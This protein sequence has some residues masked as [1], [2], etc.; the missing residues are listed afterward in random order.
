MPMLDVA[1]RSA[2][3]LRRLQSRYLPTRLDRIKAVHGWTRE[4]QLRYLI[5]QVRA[6]P[7]RAL[8]VELGVWQGRSVLALAEACRGTGK[9][10]FAIDPWADYDEGGGPVSGYLA[11]YGVRSFEEVYQ[12]YLAHCRRLALEEWIVTVRAPSVETARTWSRGPVSLVFID[13][14]HHY[15]AVSADLEAWVPLVRPDGVVCGDDWEWDSVRRAVQDFVA[16][17][18]GYAIELPCDNTWAFVVKPR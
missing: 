11:Q 7:D 5:R 4:V 1:R 15:D 3:L 10:V 6:L 12:A 14:S 16:R 8:V 17:H 13:A 9:R 18:P 2:G